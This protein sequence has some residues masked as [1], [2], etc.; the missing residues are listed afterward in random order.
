[1]AKVKKNNQAQGQSFEVALA[2]LGRII[3]KMEDGDMPLEEALEAYREGTELM[4]QCQAR[5]KEA[6]HLVQVLEGQQL[7]TMN[8]AL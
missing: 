2:D 1:M 6:E 5:L 4:L 3:G 7:T 8:V